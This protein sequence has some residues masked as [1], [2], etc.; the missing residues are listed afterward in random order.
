MHSWL[1]VGTMNFYQPTD[2][3][4]MFHVHSLSSESPIPT[5]LTTHSSSTAHMQVSSLDPIDPGYS[6]YIARKRDAQT[7][8]LALNKAALQKTITK[9]SFL[10]PIQTNRAHKALIPSKQWSEMY[11]YKIQCDVGT[12]VLWVGKIHSNIEKPLSRHFRRNIELWS[13]EELLQKSSRSVHIR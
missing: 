6:M 12:Y 8:Y 9:I 13:P 7:E 11:W 5:T 4:H 1:Q 10:D 3:R 2:I